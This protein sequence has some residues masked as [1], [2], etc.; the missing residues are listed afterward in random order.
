MHYRA[1]IQTIIIM[2]ITITINFFLK[3]IYK[4]S[5]Y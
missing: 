3:G 4:I 5:F 2:I 1:Y